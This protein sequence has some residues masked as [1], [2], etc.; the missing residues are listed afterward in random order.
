M[1]IEDVK[2]LKTVTVEAQAQELL[3]EGWMLLACSTAKKGVA[4][5]LSSIW[6]KRPTPSL[7]RNLR[8]LCKRLRITDFFVKS[9]TK[10]SRQSAGFFA[11]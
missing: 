1:P 10:K 6:A 9:G 11:S 3:N 8:T 7:K 5:G 4:S 2:Q